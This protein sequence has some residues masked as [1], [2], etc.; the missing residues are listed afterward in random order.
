LETLSQHEAQLWI[1]VNAL[2]ERKQNKAYEEAVQILLQLKDV[3]S[4]QGTEAVFEGHIAQLQKRYSRL[5][6]LRSR[7]AQVDL[8]S[9]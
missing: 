3:A 4:Y 7:L 6:G 9:E 5:S 8:L 1:K 2:I